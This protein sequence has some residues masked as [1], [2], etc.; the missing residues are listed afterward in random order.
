MK[1]SSLFLSCFAAALLCA[2]DQTRVKKEAYDQ[3]FAAGKDAGLAEATERARAK[4]AARPVQRPQGALD[5]GKAGVPDPQVRKI[6]PNSNM[7]GS[8][9]DKKQGR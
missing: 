3:G 5:T 2:C 4:Q 8:S 9:L 1:R 7:Q 6:F